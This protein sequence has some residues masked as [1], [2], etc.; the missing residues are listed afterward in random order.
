LI[1]AAGTLRQS[2]LNFGQRI[3]RISLHDATLV[4][5]LAVTWA[6]ICLSY[7]IV[8]EALRRDVPIEQTSVV[9]S[10][11]RRL[12]FGH[13]GGRN[14]TTASEGSPPPW[15]EYA[16]LEA[17]RIIRWFT[18]LHLGW[19]DGV[20]SAW[21][22]P[23]GALAIAVIAIFILS[24]PRQEG[25][26]AFLIAFSGI[27]WNAFIINQSATHEFSTMYGLGFGLIFYTAMLHGLSHYRFASLIL[28]AFSLGIFAF[29]HYRVYADNVNEIH[30]YDVYTEDYNRI[31]HAIQGSKRNIY[32]TFPNNCAIENSKCFVLGF[33]L[34][35]N[36]ITPDYSV[37]DYVLTGAVYHTDKPFL[38]PGDTDG[39]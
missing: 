1:E 18:P 17:E 20:V 26:I 14:T 32:H 4:L 2:G 35:D 27:V 29:Q 33:Y 15:G 13:E 3:K 30:R 22:Y 23:L 12:P 39:L 25:Y 24:L 37:A 7:N 6:G 5:I 36:Y 21:A 31:Y 16:G 9:E 19:D 8:V 11:L 28:L 10:A 34:G 38:L